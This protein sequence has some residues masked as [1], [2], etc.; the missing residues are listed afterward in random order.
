MVKNIIL[1][2]LPQVLQA[3]Y[4]A[5]P[6]RV[7]LQYQ[8]VLLQQLNLVEALLVNKLPQEQKTNLLQPA[9]RPSHTLLLIKVEK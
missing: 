6:Q 5:L 3:V 8:Q 4:Y 9:L 7:P 2:P 1:W